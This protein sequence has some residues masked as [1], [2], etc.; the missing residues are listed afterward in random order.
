MPQPARLLVQRRHE[1]G[2][3]VAIYKEQPDHVLIVAVVHGRSVKGAEAFATSRCFALTN[4]ASHA[5]FA[6]IFEPGATPRR[7]GHSNISGPDF[8]HAPLPQP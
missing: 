8:D 1:H 7:H 6:R 4:R 2:S 3:H 5:L